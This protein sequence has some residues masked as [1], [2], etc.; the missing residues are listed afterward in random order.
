MALMVL[1]ILFAL[2]IFLFVAYFPIGYADYYGFAD[3]KRY[4]VLD[5]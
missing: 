1:I 3:F 4:L 5:K 2:R